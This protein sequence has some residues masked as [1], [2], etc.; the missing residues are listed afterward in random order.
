[1][2]PC[3]ISDRVGEGLADINPCITIVFPRLFCLVLSLRV[4][5]TATRKTISTQIHNKV[6]EFVVDTLT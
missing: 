4:R 1:M 3:G 5:G 2:C 6:I